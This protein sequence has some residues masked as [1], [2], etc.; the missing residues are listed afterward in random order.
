MDKVSY[1]SLPESLHDC[2][3][4]VQIRQTHHSFLFATARHVFKLKKPVHDDRI[5]Y[6]TLAQRRWAC[7]EELRLNRRLSPRTYC[8]TL[9]VFLTDGGEMSLQRTGMIIDWLVKMRRLPEARML[10]VLIDAGTLTHREIERVVERLSGFYRSISATDVPETS[11]CDRLRARIKYIGRELRATE[12]CSAQR[13]GREIVPALLSYIDLNSELLESRFADGYVRELHGDLRP[14]HICV[15]SEIEVIDCLEF[16][17][18]L[19]KLDCLEEV[20]FL[21]LECAR[22]HVSSLERDIRGLYSQLL[23]DKTYRIDLANFYAAKQALGRAMLHARRATAK[24]A[25]EH[26]RTASEDYCRLSDRYCYA[27]GVQGLS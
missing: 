12:L 1:L 2:A 15:S 24:P 3:D 23:P 9:P 17:L 13:A 10:D 27:L 18:D 19:R 16:D 11:Y 8:R 22:L 14:E 26:C 4:H 6:R 21:G 7:G 25:D 5:D 20:S